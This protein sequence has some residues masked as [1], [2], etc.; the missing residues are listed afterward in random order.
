[1]I[2]VT[3]TPQIIDQLFRERYEH[4]HP[5]V[6][7]R[8]EA[9]YLKSQKLKNLQISETLRVSRRTLQ[10]WIHIFEKEGVEGLKKFNYKGQRSKLH[11][12]TETIEEYFRKHPPRS[13][14][15]ACFKVEELTGLKRG[16]TPVRKF[17]KSMGMSLRKTGGVPGKADP[18]KQEDFK[19]KRLNQFWQMPEKVKKKYIL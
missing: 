9:L 8:M 7:R 18:V 12:H 15:E 5:L 10:T 1:M 16:E 6:Q 19:K 4:P 17:L 14:Q 13:I 11:A 3:F 2:R